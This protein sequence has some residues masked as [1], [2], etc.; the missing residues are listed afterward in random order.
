[1]FF[2]GLLI[3]VAVLLAARCSAQPGGSQALQQLTAFRK[4]HRRTVDGRLC[5]AAF[6]QDDQTYTDCTTAKAP[7]GTTDKIR[8]KARQAFE[9]KASEGESMVSRLDGSIYQ[10]NESQKK[11][12]ALCGT[13]HESVG[14]QLELVGKILQRNQQCL[15]KLAVAY[16]TVRSLQEMIRMTHHQVRHQE[17]VAEK[18]PQNCRHTPGYEED[19]VPD[20]IHGAYYDNA[21]LEGQPRIRKTDRNIDVSFS[22]SGP[23]DNI[24]SH[25]YSIRES[26]NCMCWDGYLL[27]PQ[28][29]HYVFSIETDNAARVF[30][31][32]QPIIADRMPHGTSADAVGSKRVPLIPLAERA[33][34]HITESAPIRLT[35][36]KKYRIRVEFVHNTHFLVDND[37]QGSLQLMWASEDTKREVIPPKYFFTSNKGSPI[38]VSSLDPNLYAVSILHEGAAAYSDNPSFH[39]RTIPGHLKGTRFIRSPQHPSAN[40][41]EF[42]VNQPANLFVGYPEHELFPLAPFEDYLWKAHPTEDA[43]VVKEKKG[44]GDTSDDQ[45]SG[46]LLVRRIFHRGGPISFSIANENVPFI[47]ALATVTDATASCGNGEYISLTFTQPVQLMKFLYMPPADP[48]MW[49]SE[50]TLTFDDSET[51]VFRILHTAKLEHHSYLLAMPR[52][53]TKVQ[54]EVTQMYVN[55]DDSGGSFEFWGVPCV[56]EEEESSLPPPVVELECLDTLSSA[57]QGRSPATGLQLIAQCGA[58]CFDSPGGSVYGDKLYSLESTICSAGLHASICSSGSPCTLFVTVAGPQ[59]EF[60]AVKRNGI[61]SMSHGP[62]EA[63]LVLA[64]ASCTHSLI[65]EPP[66]KL[67]I[68]FGYS[69]IPLP[70]AVHS[71]HAMSPKAP[72]NFWSISVPQNGLYLVAVELGNPCGVGLGAEPAAAYLEVNGLPLVRNLKIQKGKFYTA[73]VFANVTERLIVLT[74]SCGHELSGQPKEKDRMCEAAVTTLLNVTIEKL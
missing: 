23:L 66:A 59:Q 63:A 27:I 26:L 21:L 40:L 2:T 22:G 18:R 34:K 42:S 12:D 74:S 51:E 33:G 55:G 38:K 4:N 48:L 58:K 8:L 35:G 11:F 61:M 72:A 7:N 3:L 9:M 17:E 31:N 54:I 45:G 60:P 19:P 14:S 70:Q 53:V 50:I 65:R 68:H 71:Q 10:T 20:G 15:K 37:D 24:P 28:T 64:H 41:M 69:K 39:L 46:K 36:K 43:F 16:T 49:P 6:V 5:A 62:A 30:L 29:A 47:I 73:T 57:L 1:M 56:T 67:K 13:R 25:K 44:D 32:G 52:I